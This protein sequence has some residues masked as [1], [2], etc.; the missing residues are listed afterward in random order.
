MIDQV[1]SDRYE[2]QKQLSNHAGRRTFVARDF[3]RKELVIVKLLT[4]GNGFE[5]DHLRLFE[6]EAKILQTLSHPAIPKYLDYFDVD[7]PNGKGFALVQTYIDARSLDVHLEAGR[8]F[9]LAEVKQIASN[10]LEILIYLHE[11]RPPIIHRDIKPSNILLANGSAHSAGEVYLVDFGS[12][13]NCAAVEGGTFTIV[14]SYGYMPLE[15]FGGRSVPASDLYALGATLIY[16]LTRVH[17]ANLPQQDSRIQF[18][19]VTELSSDLSRWLKKMLEPSLDRRFSSALVA[20]E[21][22]KKSQLVDVVPTVARKP[23]G[24]KNSHPKNKQD[25]QI[26]I[27]SLL[28]LLCLMYIKFSNAIGQHLVVFLFLILIG[29][30]AFFFISIDEF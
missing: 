6:R 25:L 11:Q 27:S 12:V 4:F 22:L 15:Q 18:E 20:L 21:A 9:S 28:I 8:S 7:L 17:P 19:Q 2:I 29:W 10:L 3:V 24:R 16:L 23:A 30:F 1:L 5:W 14:G 13:Q 26:I